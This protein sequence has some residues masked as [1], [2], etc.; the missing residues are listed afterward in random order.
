MYDNVL[1]VLHNRWIQS[2]GVLLALA[3]A[4]LLFY[5]ISPLLIPVFLAMLVAY[6]LSPV[7]MYLEAR[8]VRRTIT[9]GAMAFISLLVLISIPI[10]VVPRLLNEADELV[11]SARRAVAEELRQPRDAVR[12]TWV[13]KALDWFPM[14]ELVI[15]M[16]WWPQS[17]RLDVGA[18]VPT[19]A[20]TTPLSEKAVLLPEEEYV[21]A[22]EEISPTAPPGAPAPAAT[23]QPRPGEPV[24]TDE[25]ARAIVADHVYTAVRENLQELTRRYAG[26]VAASIKSGTTTVGE[27]LQYISGSF[28][29]ILAFLVNFSVFAFATGY[30]MLSFDRLVLH[31]REAIPVQYRERTESILTKIDFQMRSFVRGQLMVA[32]VNALIFGVGLTVSG[33]PFGFLIGLL[34]G[35]LTFIPY[36]GVLFGLITSVVLVL[37]QHG[38]DWHIV[39]VLATFGIAQSIEE[40]VSRPLILGDKIGLHPVWVMAAFLVFGHSFGFLG[41]LLAV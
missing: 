15:T 10:F 22:P 34:T 21:V 27:L 3:L 24:L 38:F 13:S 8:G 25:L 31:A 6:L 32:T 16:G 17:E 9:T 2:L 18:T 36:V 5:F 12:D 11:T 20:V 39:G 35:F 30:L 1:S 7:V 33:V 37:V 14:Q 26:Q 29:K 28:I 4:A 23:E 19:A 40:V 41:V